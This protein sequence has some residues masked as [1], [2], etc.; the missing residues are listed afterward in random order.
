[1]TCHSINVI[2][3]NS[4]YAGHL[5]Q[6][7]ALQELIQNRAVLRVPHATKATM[8]PRTV[9]TNASRA[10]LEISAVI[11]R[12][13]QYRANLAFSPLH[14]KPVAFNALPVFMPNRM[15]TPGAWL[16]PKATDVLI[17]HCRLNFVSPD[18]ILLSD[19][20]IAPY[21]LPVIIQTV[22]TVVNRALLGI[23]VTIRV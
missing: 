12:P 1:M 3:L 7:N 17:L 16:V 23:F 5:L 20:Q 8:L 10:Q 18:F 9:V 14:V 13:N 2:L 19:K 4:L 22:P 6:W 21:V 11:R 15:V